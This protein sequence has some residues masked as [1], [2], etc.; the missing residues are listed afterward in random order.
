MAGSRKKN[1]ARFTTVQEIVK[2]TNA[3]RFGHGSRLQ[4]V[5][6]WLT[7]IVVSP[8]F[9]LLLSV[10]IAGWILWTESS[11]VPGVMPYEAPPFPWLQGVVSL[12][13][14]YLAAMILGT[15]RREDKLAAHRDRSTLDL[16]ILSER[17]SAKIIQ[18]L[19]EIRS[20]S[21]NLFNRV[22]RG[23]NAVSVQA[24]PQSIQD[25]ISG[26]RSPPQTARERVDVGENTA[27]GTTEAGKPWLRESWC[28]CRSERYIEIDGVE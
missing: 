16:A 20:D 15:Q 14:L 10:L 3:A 5:A 26:A 13:A 4:R 7:S 1:V 23:A 24:N 8:A 22:D 18:L 17:K 2:Q 6:H 9:A 21:P 25:A 11:F 12:T 19:E 28:G 27:P